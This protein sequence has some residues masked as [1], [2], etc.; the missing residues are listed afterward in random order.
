MKVPSH[1]GPDILLVVIVLER[2]VNRW[3]RIAFPIEIDISPGILPIEVMITSGGIQ[4][5]LPWKTIIETPA[6]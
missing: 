4:F 2:G 3:R 6:L 1:K 5:V